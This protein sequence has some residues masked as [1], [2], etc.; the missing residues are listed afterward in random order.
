MHTQQLHARADRHTHICANTGMQITTTHTCHP[1]DQKSVR[2]IGQ[3]LVGQR[4][5]DLDCPQRS[6]T[7]SACSGKGDAIDAAVYVKAKVTEVSNQPH[8]SQAITCPSIQTLHPKLIALAATA[9]AVLSAYSENVPF[10][11][12]EA[13]V[14]LSVLWKRY[15]VWNN[16]WLLGSSLC[17]HMNGSLTPPLST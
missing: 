9:S 6:R 15:H 3:G 10:M 16:Y 4:H 14:M 17:L 8:S 2:A 13:L 11:Q 5:E 12:D 7:R 1:D